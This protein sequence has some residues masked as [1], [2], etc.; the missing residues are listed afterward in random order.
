[1]ML[2]RSIRRIRYWLRHRERE[3]LL[4]EE[5]EFHLDMKTHELTEDGMGESEA[6]AAAVQQFGNILLKQEESRGTWIARWLSDL[7]QDVAYALRVLRKQPGFAAVCVLSASLGI[8]ACSTIFGIANYALFHPLPVQDSTRLAS[9]YGKNV[10]R[11]KVGQTLSWPDFEDI[12]RASSL[13]GAAAFFPLMPATISRDGDPQRHWGSVVTLNY[14]DVVR[15][16]F[17]LGRGFNERRDDVSAHTQAVVLSHSLWQSRFAGD[18]SIVGKTVELNGRKTTVAGVTAPGFRGTEPIFFSEFWIPFSTTDSLAQFGI[19]PERFHERGNQWLQ[20]TGR[21]RDGM[22][23]GAA[24]AE[25]EAIGAHL[26]SAWPATNKDRAFYVERAGQVN[27]GFRKMITVFFFVLLGVTLLVLL[28]ACANVANLLLARAWSREKEIATRLAIGAGRARIVRQLLTESLILAA[29]GGAGGYVIAQLGTRLLGLSQVPLSFPVD[30]AIV[31]DFRVTL[32]CIALS[33]ITGL[34]FGLV[35]ALRATRRDLVCSL[36]DRQGGKSASQR[37][38]GLR[39]GL[40]VAQVTV[41]TLLLICSGLFLRSLQ[42]ARSI[43]PGFSHRNVLLLSLDPAMNGYSRETTRLLIERVLEGTSMLPGVE[44]ASL[45]SSVPLNMEGT[46]NGFTPEPGKDIMVADI[47]SVTPGFFATL[48]IR[49]IGGEDFRPGVPAE[50]IAIANQALASKAFGGENPVGRVIEYQGRHV[51]INGL[52]TTTKSRTIGEEPRPALYFPMLR[53]LRGNDS[54]TGM[55]LLVRTSGEPGVYMTAMR[56]LIRSIDPGLAV[57]EVRTMDSQISRALYPPRAAASLFGISGVMGLIIA[58]VGLYGVMSFVVA[59][60]TTEIGIRMAL[61][62]RRIQVLGTVLRHGLGLTAA[63]C[64]VGLC[65]ALALGR[66][67]ASLL[68]GVSPTDTATYIAVAALLLVIAAAA[69]LMPARRAASVDPII[70]L[71]Y[72]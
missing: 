36:K 4:R 42:S 21:L 41:C 7:L 54:L 12:R 10:T 70:T 34:V 19:K 48:G 15:P 47:Y 60:R 68:Y 16:R 9:I 56:Q 37:G 30:L 40:V 11:G 64:V 53:E 28:T 63:G 55:T 38:L 62:A 39:D 65:L 8:G 6:R 44:A 58:A 20:I 1:M 59:G 43:H 24:A 14:F 50:D 13:Q 18:L 29:L 22:S 2:R 3:R 57:F 61:G 69:C 67:T 35:P 32:F 27:P 26:R 23:L 66:A 5:M 46:Q 17:V 45:T 49:F 52:V 51:R 31:L 72:E 33:A 71:K 25:I